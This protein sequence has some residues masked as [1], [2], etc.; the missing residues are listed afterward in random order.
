MGL[1]EDL[2]NLSEQVKKRKDYIQ[3]EE[4]TKHSLVLPFLQV[5]GFDVYDPREVK[6]EYVADFATK[7]S[8][9]QLRKVD[10]ALY[11]R[12]ELSIFLECKAVDVAVEDQEGQLAQYFNSTPSVKL[13]IITNGIQ[14]RFFTDLR[15]QHIM[16][17]E[18]FLDFNIL[19]FT[20][21]EA[22]ALKPLTKESYNG[23][24][25]QRYAEEIISAEKVTALIGELLTNPSENFVRFIL[26]E[27]DLVAGKKNANVIGRFTPIVKKA[28]QAALLSMMT[29]SFQQGLTPP[30]AAP[31]EPPA[32]EPSLQA[33]D[34]TLPAAEPG[35]GTKEGGGAVTTEEELAIFQIVSRLCG[36][37]SLKSA[38]KY[39]DT[40]AYFGIN[41]GVVTRWFLRIYTGGM[42][43]SVVT[44]L[45]VAQAT[46]LAPGFRVESAPENLGKSRVYFNVP[47][48]FE[49]LRALVIVAYEE[50]VKRRDSNAPDTDDAAG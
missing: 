4:A 15:L 6:P 45:P 46:M 36:E 50:E 41:I 11:V 43:K 49:R 16:D 9:K 10:Y 8:G 44:R 35:T 21:R 42:R 48:D 7:L 12:G 13:G 47:T 29:K 32:P 30:P 39:K 22:E 23:S 37:S 33:V 31:P 25:V 27:L 26:D 5:L 40:T 17:S 38:V 28:M 3:G 18:P 14:Y 20:E 24:S 34:K 19:S 2:R 1:F